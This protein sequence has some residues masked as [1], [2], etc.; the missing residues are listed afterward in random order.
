MKE[1][2]LEVFLL[3]HL[4]LGKP[5]QSKRK[6]LVSL[7]GLQVKVVFSKEHNVFPMKLIF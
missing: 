6:V 4:I 1:G 5:V 3:P 7:I 2:R